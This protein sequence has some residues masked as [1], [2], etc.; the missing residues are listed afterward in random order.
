MPKAKRSSTRSSTSDRRLEGDLTRAV[1]ETIS[2]IK[3][4]KAQKPSL[5]DA[6][7]SFQDAD[8][9][10]RK[11]YNPLK[12]FIEIL[13]MSY[14]QLH[15]ISKWFYLLAD[16]RPSEQLDIASL[17]NLSVFVTGFQRKT[18]ELIHAYSLGMEKLSKSKGIDA[19][20][21]SELY[22]AQIVASSYLG[23]A[24]KLKDSPGFLEE[25]H[26]R[27]DD[28]L[29]RL[30]T[31]LT[32]AEQTAF[33][34]VCDLLIT[35]KNSTDWIRQLD[36]WQ[37]EITSGQEQYRDAYRFPY[38]RMLMSGEMRRR[39]EATSRDM[40]E[41]LVLDAPP[42]HAQLLQSSTTPRKIGVY[43]KIDNDVKRLIG[44][45]FRWSIDG[46][47]SEINFS[48]LSADISKVETAVHDCEEKHGKLIN[49][50]ESLETELSRLEESVIKQRKNPDL[51]HT[52]VNA[53]PRHLVRARFQTWKGALQRRSLSPPL[54]GSKAIF[55]PHAPHV[56]APLPPAPKTKPKAKHPGAETL[57]RSTVPPASH[58]HGRPTKKTDTE[59]SNA[60]IRIIWGWDEDAVIGD[61]GESKKNLWEHYVPTHVVAAKQTCHENSILNEVQ[62]GSL[63]RVIDKRCFP[64]NF[65]NFDLRHVTI[66]NG[67]L[68]VFFSYNPQEIPRIIRVLIVG[69]HVGKDNLRYRGCGALPGSSVFRKVN[70]D[71]SKSIR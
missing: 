57:P 60:S 42:N 14:N 9:S 47:S 3:L 29:S 31:R 38:E 36:E 11:K 5:V 4:L 52:I 67:S 35:I 41:S 56:S 12:Q 32:T 37:R 70:V 21:R 13:M 6:L 33:D 1:D 65:R 63:P 61:K 55:V 54:A 24:N 8:K 51:F 30:L 39:V 64:P 48:S 45:A 66:C 44:R 15:E 69:R 16:S 17:R 49:R 43:E 68:S 25:N 34:S 10:D 27:I 7:I 26:A 22:T 71:L 28:N 18:N 53:Y 2:A 46:D 58:I 40:D 50:F 59:S 62:R 20:E 19:K 23:R